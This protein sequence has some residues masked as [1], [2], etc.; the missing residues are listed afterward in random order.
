MKKILI[1][2][3]VIG[4]TSFSADAKT[5]KNSNCSKNPNY[6]VCLSNGTYQV[7]GKEGSKAVNMNRDTQT[8]EVSMSQ[9]TAD[10]DVNTV[11]SYEG[12]YRKHN[13]LVSDE[14][15]KPYKG[16]ASRQWD[17]PAKNEYRNMNYNN[18]TEYIAPSSGN[19]TK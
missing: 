14:M 15:D 17:G 10:M 18:T 4:V 8:W 2:L 16:E 19:N 5:K 3:I 7:C 9:P 12:F 13:I 6:R 11:N 1:A